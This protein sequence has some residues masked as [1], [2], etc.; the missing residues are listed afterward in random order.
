M[1]LNKLRE[2]IRDVNIE[3]LAWLRVRNEKLFRI[4]VRL[5]SVIKVDDEEN[6][7]IDAELAEVA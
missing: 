1:T 3:D 4:M 2:E 6:A 5:T 7:K